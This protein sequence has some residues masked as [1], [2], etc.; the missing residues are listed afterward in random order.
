[1]CTGA[2][3]N[4]KFS[5]LKEPLLTEDGPPR[6]CNAEAAFPQLTSPP[7]SRPATGAES[8]S[9]AISY[10][11]AFVITTGIL[12]LQGLLAL[13]AVGFPIMNGS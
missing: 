8:S 3:S 6:A 10:I 1:M 11:V 9:P 7:E 2:D 4:I 12:S 13:L 5:D